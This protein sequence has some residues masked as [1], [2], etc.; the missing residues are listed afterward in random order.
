MEHRYDV[1][2]E[3]EFDAILDRIVRED[4]HLLL[5]IPGVYEV[6]SE[7]YINEVLAE[8]EAGREGGTE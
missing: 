3:E 1:C 4:V 6:V 8:W 2:P 5:S 7:Y